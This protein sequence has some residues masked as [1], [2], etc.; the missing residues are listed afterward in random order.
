MFQHLAV[1]VEYLALGHE[2]Y[3]FAILVN[4]GQIPGSGV[5]KCLHYLLHWSADDDLGG[6]NCHEAVDLHASVQVR[7]EHDVADV[8]ELHNA[9]EF[10]V[11]VG[12]RE[13]VAMTLCDNVYHILEAH[14]GVNGREI[15][16]NHAVHLQQCKYRTVLLVCEQLA[17]LGKTAGVDAVGGENAA[18][19]V[20]AG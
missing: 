18:D 3:I 15:F 13:K 8:V 5:V 1:A 4:D 17:S 7:A 12:D 10:P 11:V 19:A 6:R 16:L 14:V 20:T 9:D 2:A